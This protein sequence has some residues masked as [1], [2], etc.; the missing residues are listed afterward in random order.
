MEING[1]YVLIPGMINVS[2]IRQD[3]FYGEI[4]IDI[5]AIIN[6]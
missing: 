1:F 5:F 3:S 2:I 6:S 4:K